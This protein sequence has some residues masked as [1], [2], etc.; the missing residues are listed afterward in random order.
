ML[1]NLYSWFGVLFKR[2]PL[3]R[4]RWKATHIYNCL[5]NAQDHWLFLSLVRELLKLK[6]TQKRRFSCRTC[7]GKIKSFRTN[8]RSHAYLKKYNTS[9][10]YKL[11]VL[12]LNKNIGKMNRYCV[13]L[14]WGSFQLAKLHQTMVKWMLHTQLI[15]QK[16]L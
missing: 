3:F 8:S 5:L 13:Q 12:K 7:V 9:I 10:V 4:N 6:Q 14:P 2:L 15:T 1:S 11:F 16:L